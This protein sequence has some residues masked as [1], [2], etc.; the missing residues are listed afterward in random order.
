[1][2][3]SEQKKEAVRLVMEA[4]PGEGA[5]KIANKLG[6]KPSY[7]QG[8]MAAL[9]KGAGPASPLTST[10]IEETIPAALKLLAKNP[11]TPKSLSEALGVSMDQF[12]DL[13]ER[14]EQHAV[15]QHGGFLS[16]GTPSFGRLDFRAVDP[17]TE[18]Q[19]CGLVADTHLCCREERL[20]ELHATYDL[21]KAE[22]VSRVFHAGNLV[23]GYVQRINGA[24]VVCT[25]PDDQAQYVIDNY[26][27]R[28]GLVTHFIT[29]DDHEGWWI[30]EGLNWGAFLQMLAEKQGRTDLRYIGHVEADVEFKGPT[31]STVM[32]VQH[33]GGGSAYARSYRPQKQIESF[34][35]GE[36]PQILVQGHYHVSN[37][38]DDRNVHVINLPGFQ[39]QTV[40][41]R[42]K[43]LR[44]EIGGAI[45]RFKAA[46]DGSVVRCQVEFKRFYNR[47][48]YK[49]WLRSDSKILK[50]HLVVNS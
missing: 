31:A 12:P 4:Y 8:I 10:G 2:A 1:M 3:S 27:A 14:L 32:K 21:F 11:M 35:G 15:T 38:M 23:D 24:S 30:K 26:P 50:G 29:G 7:V 46:P 16:I 43:Q 44:F 25:T 49:S 6:L 40:F 19:V 22:G 36:K 41:A 33:P 47:G 42:K 9:Q 45:L 34:E 20:S 48:Y 13:L 39:D 37:Y 5:R 18:W 28:K 17:L